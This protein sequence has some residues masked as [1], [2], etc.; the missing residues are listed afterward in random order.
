MRRAGRV[1]L[2]AIVAAA[3]GFWPNSASAADALADES[4]RFERDIA[5]ILAQNCVR[6]HQRSEPKGGLD[7]ASRA[8]AYRGGESG[9]AVVPR[10]TVKSLLLDYIEGDKP[11]MP[12][13]GPPLTRK[14]IE[15][16]KRWIADGAAWPESL[17]LKEDR[18]AW[19]SLQPIVRS[20]VPPVS[21]HDKPQVRNPIDAFLLAKLREQKLGMAGDADR[22]TLIRR[23]TFDLTGLPPAPEEVDAFVQSTDPK[24]YEILVDRLLASPR[25][26][27]RWARHWLDVVHYGDTHGYDK[28]KRRPNA[29][30]YRD[31]VIRALNS[32]K[33]YSR[34]VEEQI[35]GD[36]LWPKTIDGITGTGFLAAGP[37]DF[38]GQVELREGTIDKQITRSLD[39]DDMLASTMGTFVSMTVHCARCHDHKF[40][41]IPQRDYYSL[42]AV[43]AAVDRADRPFDLDPDAASR[44]TQLAATKARL[45]S[46]WA[47][48]ERRI[49]EKAGPE[50]VRLEK[51]LDELAARS[52]A[53]PRPEFGYHSAISPTQDAAKWVQVDLG[54]STEINDVVIVGCHD[55]FNNIG[56]GFGFP[57][58]YRID[59]SDDP[60][61]KSSVTTLVDHTRAD[62]PNPKVRPQSVRGDG[63]KARYLRVTA[64]KLAPRQN[65]YIFALAELSIVTPD[66]V[67]A[68]RGATVTSLDS[69][70]ALPRWSRKNLVDDYYF[71]ADTPEARA[72]ITRLS[73]RRDALLAAALNEEARRQRAT[74]RAELDR[75][76]AELASAAPQGRVFAAATQFPP[77]GNLTPTLGKPRPIHILNRGD[78]KSPGA[79]A[80]PGS[81]SCVTGLAAQFN[82]PDAGNEGARR[83]ALARW[84]T[85]AKNPLTWRSIVNRVWHYHFGRGL[86]ESPNDFG[87]M[88][89]LPT[90]PE[91]LDWLATEFRDGGQSL[92]QLHRLIVTSSAYRAQSQPQSDPISAEW[93]SRAE[94]ADAG[95]RYLWRMNRRRLDA[96]EIRDATLSVSG[97]LDLTMGGPGFDLFGFLDDHSPH[98][99]Y[100][101]YDPDNPRTLRRSVYRFIVRSVPDPFMETLDCADPSLVTPV[102]QATTTPLQ[103]LTLLN[104]RFM[105]RQAQR[106]ASRVEAVAGV[107]AVDNPEATVQTAFRLTLGRTPTAD[108]LATL[109]RYT[110]EHGLANACRLL[111]NLNEFVFV[112]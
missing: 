44:R 9:P 39:R 34:F 89:Q 93:L 100:E 106:L 53:T 67:N 75:V 47:D 64:T 42:Q 98:Y 51:Q 28:D 84:I 5:P 49:V 61:M 56:A 90:H 83:V 40:D 13:A 19:W 63:L 35:A 62:V 101:E 80:N 81:L 99:K 45:E 23:V 30:P 78:V 15:K 20:P 74:L 59:A 79:E 54:R 58:R 111:L 66:G 109:A 86:V 3:P 105:V 10:T 43:F 50:F 29:W 82:L 95:N 37:W 27:E 33:P 17:V 36:I 102:R 14:Q 97:S 91:L 21:E 68:A 6:C 108:E 94:S 4:V 60:E 31:Y 38:V 85:D 71:G 72:E 8:G 22:R 11:L 48:L 76:A 18:G 25:Y 96:E 103:A 55:N 52:Q 7:L 112:D 77:A 87:R 57:V 107:K 24:A 46:A 69:I 16:L 104:N 32:D 41:P 92:K 88:G 110:Q 65:D 70:E 12:K 73:A 2:I 26:G 1:I